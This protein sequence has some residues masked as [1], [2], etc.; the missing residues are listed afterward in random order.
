M[1]DPIENMIAEFYAS[2]ATKGHSWAASPLVGDYCQ[3]CGATR[4]GVELEATVEAQERL[5]QREG[6]I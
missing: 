6:L 1:T 4:R 5:T 2:C 3:A